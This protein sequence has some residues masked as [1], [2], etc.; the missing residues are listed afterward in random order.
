MYSWPQPLQGNAE[1][2][3]KLTESPQTNEEVISLSLSVPLLLSVYVCALA[4][5]RTCT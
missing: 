2:P 5:V 3:V 4:C 1:V